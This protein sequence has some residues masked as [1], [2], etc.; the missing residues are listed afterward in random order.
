[1]YERIS[2]AQHKDLKWWKMNFSLMHSGQM[3]LSVVNVVQESIEFAAAND[4]SSVGKKVTGPFIW[5]IHILT[6]TKSRPNFLCN[7]DFL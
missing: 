2:K 3:A 6:F 5:I 7:V 4:K 1:M